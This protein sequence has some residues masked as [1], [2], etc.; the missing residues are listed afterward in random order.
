MEVYD[1]SSLKRV[2]Y[3]SINQNGSGSEIDR[4]IYNQNGEGLG[5]FF[6]NVMKKAIPF[7]GKAIKGGW[8]VAKPHLTAAGK[9]LIVAGAK[10]GIETISSPKKRRARATHK[11]HKKRAKWQSL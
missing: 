4:Y 10:K 2:A 8:N 1:P 5:S 7:L 11:T 3:V 9:D 6:G